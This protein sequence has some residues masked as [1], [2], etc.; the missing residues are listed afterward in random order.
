MIASMPDLMRGTDIVTAERACGHTGQIVPNER[1]QWHGAR[2]RALMLTP[3]APTAF[4]N[5]PA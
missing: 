3:N 5:T 2:R 4:P 1:N